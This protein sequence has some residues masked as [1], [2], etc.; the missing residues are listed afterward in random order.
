MKLDEARKFALSLPEANEEPHHKMSSFRVRGKIFTT[1][2]ED[3]EHIHVFVDEER[4]ESCLAMFPEFC[5]KLWW[6]K[7]VVGLRITLSRADPDEV[8]D[9]VRAAWQ[10]KAPKSLLSEP[11]GD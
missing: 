11:E 5:E 2:T 10:V 6:G 1:I 4:R 9:L 3:E 8:K 7:K